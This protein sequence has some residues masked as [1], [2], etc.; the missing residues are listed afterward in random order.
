M[1][2]KEVL[3]I[4]EENDIDYKMV[5]ESLVVYPD[6]YN[7]PN[8]TG[9]YIVLGDVIYDQEENVYE[10]DFSDNFDEIPEDLAAW[11]NVFAE[12]NAHPGYT[13]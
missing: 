9:T 5:N 12:T 7:L 1:N 6:G 13:N 4:I 2:F 3:N 10:F 11:L 8:S